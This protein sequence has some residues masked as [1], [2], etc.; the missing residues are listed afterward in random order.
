MK[1]VEKGESTQ[2]LTAS[3][4]LVVT[5]PT[6]AEARAFVTGYKTGWRDLLDRVKRRIDDMLGEI[7]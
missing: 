1:I 4:R 7:S 3:G 5:Y 6:P 2:V